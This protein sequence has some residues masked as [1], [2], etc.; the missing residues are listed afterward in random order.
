MGGVDASVH[1]GIA[2]LERH[3]HT[4]ADVG[5]P[6]VNLADRSVFDA[7]VD[8][9]AAVVKVD[10]VPARS[11]RETAALRLIRDRAI[12]V[13]EP[14]H[15]IDPVGAD[16]AVLVLAR[17]DGTAL[18]G[19]LS[20][21]TWREAGFALRRIHATLP[22][23]EFGEPRPL[24]EHVE[25]WHEREMRRSS[26]NGLLTMAHRHAIHGL[27]SPVWQAMAEAPQCLVHGDAQAEHFL[28]GPDRRIAAVVDFAD[29][30]VGDPVCDL[31]VLT[32]DHPGQLDAVLSGYRPARSTRERIAAL[33]EPYRIL[34]RVAAANWMR[35]NGLDP[36]AHLDA[37]RARVPTEPRTIRM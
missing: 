25:E 32:L 23:P 35:D 9:R 1:A 15:H 34:R 26:D 7:T 18:S 22:S 8:G 6:R 17:I 28:I 11:A 10:S 27:L 24:R 19:H 16:P 30:H 12:P 5:R 13:P 33:I 37:L 29:A 3:G 36:T 14:L 4:V 2:A 20:S 21:A 31:A